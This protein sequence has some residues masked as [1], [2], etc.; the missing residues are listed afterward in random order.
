M[1]VE[2]MEVMGVLGSIAARH[3]QTTGLAYNTY[4]AWSARFDDIKDLFEK[5][6]KTVH[7]AQSQ[8]REVGTLDKTGIAMQLAAS[9]PWFI[10]LV[11]QTLSQWQT[12]IPDAVQ[13]L[14]E[15]QSSASAAA[16]S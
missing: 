5:Y 12:R 3:P 16:K 15:F 14:G 1:S 2:Y 11:I 9:N 4:S 7:E 13:I 10:Q 8:G 6:Q